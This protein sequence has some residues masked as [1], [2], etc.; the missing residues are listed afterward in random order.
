M[1]LNI[2]ATTNS[3]S[4]DRRLIAQARLGI[5][6]DI[7]LRDEFTWLT[8]QLFV[9]VTVEFKT[10]ANQLNQVAIWSHIIEDKV[11]ISPDW[12]A[13]TFLNLHVQT[14]AYPMKPLCA[15]GLE[16]VLDRSSVIC[17]RD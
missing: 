11:V 14:V 7:D 17:I 9:Y 10:A 4:H 8:K 15:D 13:E 1:R 12:S 6:V 16:V 2:G 3:V 5:D